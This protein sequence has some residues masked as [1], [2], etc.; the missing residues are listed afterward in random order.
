MREAEETINFILNFERSY[1]LLQN[2]FKKRGKHLEKMT[3]TRGLWLNFSRF[4]GIKEKSGAKR[5][6][7]NDFIFEEY[8]E[9]KK[10]SL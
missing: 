3:T 8:Q 5:S 4:S 2:F 7:L 9:Y 6:V 10:S 1:N